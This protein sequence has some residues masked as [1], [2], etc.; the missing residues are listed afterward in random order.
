M[1][2]VEEALPVAVRERIPDVV[3]SGAAKLLVLG[4]GLTFGVL[5]AVYRPDGGDPLRDGS[6]L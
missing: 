5:Y 2:T 1:E 3:E 6:T 4:Y